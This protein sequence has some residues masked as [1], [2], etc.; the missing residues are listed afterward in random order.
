MTFA[1][2]AVLLVMLALA[3]VFGVFLV[4]RRW[5]G[6]ATG[7]LLGGFS[8]RRRALKAEELKPKGLEPKE[9]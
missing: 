1:L 5:L 7:A 2:V 3:G 6:G 4:V 9:L 8:E